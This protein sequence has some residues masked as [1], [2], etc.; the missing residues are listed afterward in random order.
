M[1]LTLN[2]KIEVRDSSIEGRGLFAK[3]PFKKGEKFEITHGEQSAVVMNDIEFEAYKKTVDSWDAVYLGSGKYKVGT[4]PREEDPSN[5]GNHSC[6]PNIAP[7]G[8]RLIALRDIAADEELTID[9]TQFSPKDWEMKC[10]CKAKNCTG[11]VKGN[12]W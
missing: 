3:E 5:Y 9:Y 4:L 7:D 6:D 11:F 8:D 2:P 10:N 12:M 1:T